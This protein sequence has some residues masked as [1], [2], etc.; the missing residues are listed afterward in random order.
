MSFDLLLNFL[1]TLQNFLWNTSSFH[2]NCFFLH[3]SLFSISGELFHSTYYS[4]LHFLLITSHSLVISSSFPLTLSC[5]LSRKL[6]PPCLQLPCPSLIALSQF[7]ISTPDLVFQT[8]TDQILN[9][10]CLGSAFAFTAVRHTPRLLH[11]H[12]S[13]HNGYQTVYLVHSMSIYGV[14]PNFISSE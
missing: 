14:L 10:L 13:S 5:R 8:F 4:F 1:W 12:C 11:W 2:V 7:S 6:N 9:G 3:V